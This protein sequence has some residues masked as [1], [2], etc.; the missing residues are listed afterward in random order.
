MGTLILGSTGFV[1][2]CKDY[3]DQINNLQQQ[4]DANKKLIEQIQ[5]LIT[6]GSVIKDVQSVDG[7][8]KIVLSN[9]KDYTITNG[10]DGKDGA[11]WTI[12]DGYWCLN[13]EKNRKQS[14]WC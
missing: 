9:G 11:A 12:K 6:N 1:T 7:G 8:I 14:Y 2:S 10:K 4:I 13:G 5:T 3:D